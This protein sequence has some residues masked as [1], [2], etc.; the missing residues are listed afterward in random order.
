MQN[1]EERQPSYTNHI[2]DI[3]AI[4]GELAEESADGDCIYRGEP[5]CYPLV[6]S[7]LFREYPNIDA[8]YFNIAVVQQAMLESAKEFV[9]QVDDGDLLTQLQHFGCSTNLIDFTTDHLI[10]L[11]FACDGEFDRDGRVILLREA[12]YSTVKAKNPVNR[13]TTQKS[14]FVMPPDGFVEPDKTVVIPH[15]LKASILEYLRKNHGLTAATIYNDIHGFI[16]YKGLHQTAFQAFYAGLSHL[17]KGENQEALERFSR[18]INLNPRMASAYVNQGSVYEYT[19]EHDD[20]IRSYTRAIELEPNAT[21]AYGNRANAYSAKG[22]YSRAIQ[23][24]NKAIA[25][26]P[27]SAAHHSDRG[28]TYKDMGEYDLAIQDYD[29]AIELEPGI[30]AIFDNRGTVYG[31]KGEHDRAIL[32]HDRA[33]HLDP[34]FPLAYNNR[35]VAYWRKGEYDRA[36]WDYDKA[37]EL[38]QSFAIAYYNRAESFILLREWKKAESDFSMA[39]TLG[40]DIAAAFH[41]EFGSI[42]EFEREYRVQLPL[43]LADILAQVPKS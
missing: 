1:R 11:F 9:G 28:T 30:A 24:H 6:S 14:V 22:D 17:R 34:H 21:A 20:A 15:D 16:R 33:I 12:A 3:L 18:A 13:V 19:G 5:D 32:D 25:L 31:A 41:G 36:V 39:K 40:M 7:S 38:N 2:A 42:P 29:K 26:A 10:A 43:T 4:L 37:I 23:D 8:E 35:G 27:S